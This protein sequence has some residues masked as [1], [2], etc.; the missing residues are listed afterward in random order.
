MSRPREWTDEKLDMAKSLMKYNSASETGE[1]L[2]TTK[3]S[4]LGVL[5]RDKIKNGHVPKRGVKRTSVYYS[6]K[7]M[8][9]RPCNMCNKMFDMHGKYDRFCSTCRRNLP[10]A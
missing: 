9:E 8:G 4:V 10:Y 5:H 3:N 7:K 2:N 6:G 1:I